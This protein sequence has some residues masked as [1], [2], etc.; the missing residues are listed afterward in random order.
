MLK[1]VG[2]NSIHPREQARAALEHSGAARKHTHSSAKTR[3]VKLKEG[4]RT[5]PDI[6]SCTHGYAW[7]AS[8]GCISKHPLRPP[9]S[10]AVLCRF[11]DSSR[12]STYPKQLRHCVRARG[13]SESPLAMAILLFGIILVVP[14]CRCPAIFFGGNVSELK[15]NSYSTT[16]SVSNLS[17]PRMTSDTRHRSGIF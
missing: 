3:T 7:S 11:L 4:P 9:R 13:I 2:L 1:W 16:S 17:T 10:A 14:F 5:C 15:P 12:F 6:P 8:C